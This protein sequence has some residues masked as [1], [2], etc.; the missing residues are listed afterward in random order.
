MISEDR[1]RTSQV[2]RHDGGRTLAISLV[3]LPFGALS[4]WCLV[5]LPVLAFCF[6]ALVVTHLEGAKA[7]AGDAVEISPPSRGVGV[8]PLFGLLAGVVAIGA[9][10]SVSLLLAERAGVHGWPVAYGAGF[11]LCL[12]V[13]VVAAPLLFTPFCAADGARALAAPWRSFAIAGALGP[14]RT[15]LLGATVGAT[16]GLP[17]LVLLYLFGAGRGAQLGAGAFLAAPFA[18]M[19]TPLVT[20]RVAARYVEATRG[21]VT[22][23][24]EIRPRLRGTLALLLPVAVALLAALVVAVF[25]PTP[26]RPL[27][28]GE[29]Q[30]A[31]TGDHW[32]HDVTS[33]GGVSVPGTSLYM[34]TDYRT[35]HVVAYD[36]GG[37]GA[38]D[39]GFS[40][41]RVTVMDA[42]VMDG[43]RGA[44]AVVA[45]HAPSTGALTL[46]D[47]DG[48]RLDDGLLDRTF[49]RLGAFSA[50]LLLLGLLGALGLLFVLGRE[51]AE[52]HALDVPRLDDAAGRGVLSGL[53]A[54]A[55]LSD[56]ATLEVSGGA[57]HV[58]GDAW[59]EA[60]AFRFRLPA[61][62]PLVGDPPEGPVTSP[63]LTLLSR[64]RGLG[65]ASLREGPAPL[66][67]DAR[68]VLGPL[69]AAAA[70]LA[71]RATRHATYLAVP[72][73]LCLAAPT[74]ALLLAL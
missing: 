66:P 27:S 9:G 3:A 33:I 71:A 25:T 65:P 48:V 55:R 59:L 26:M 8:Y 52:A 62:V 50:G 44:F 16:L 7:A 34:R 67:A 6:R 28:E 53:E 72:T 41:V 13:G 22:A 36:G 15:A 68:L 1:I 29:L 60:D 47:A 57:L 30:I 61:R 23:R 10:V 39:M 54:P 2:L 64:F 70:H 74:V 51:L 73:F 32:S 4:V 37:A 31:L 14:R 49:G 24:S 5:G 11:A 43:P 18:I 69:D 19:L 45:S 56:G 38:V 35:L 42:A 17:A 46:I 40:P 58:D 12:A 63:T 20:A 21:G